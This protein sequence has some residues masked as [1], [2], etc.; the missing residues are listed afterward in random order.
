MSIKAN[1]YTITLT[2]SDVLEFDVP[3]PSSRV[4]KPWVLPRSNPNN[5]VFRNDSDEDRRLTYDFRALTED[6]IVE[7]ELAKEEESDGEEYGGDESHAPSSASSSAP[8]SSN[9][10][11]R[12]S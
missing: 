7:I 3:D 10:V 8:R 6:E 12:S 5:I 2:E 4:P 9:R 1:T 11:V